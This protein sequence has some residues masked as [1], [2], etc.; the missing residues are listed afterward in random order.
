MLIISTY[1]WIKGKKMAQLTFS[2]E[3]L[4]DLNTGR[5]NLGKTTDVAIYRLMQYTMRKVLEARFGDEVGREVYRDAGKLAGMAF[6]RQFLNLTLSPDAFIGQLN[7]QLIDHKI[8]ILRMEK[9]DLETLHLV[10]TVSEDLDCSGLPVT[11]FTVCD[12]DEGF[13]AGIMELYLG[14]E[15]HVKEVDCWSTGDRT[16]RFDIKP[17]E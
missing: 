1:Y 16:C 4:G 11:G 6:C 14:R 3:E 15:F 12:Y 8:G 5:P 13:I 9:A 2:W 17:R 7:Q 10:M